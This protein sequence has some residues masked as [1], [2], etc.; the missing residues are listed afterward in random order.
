MA[1]GSHFVS[2]GTI[3]CT[4]Q[5]RKQHDGAHSTLN[6]APLRPGLWTHQVSPFPEAL[7]W[8]LIGG[9]NAEH[10]I[11]RDTRHTLCVASTGF[12]CLRLA[13]HLAEATFFSVGQRLVSVTSSS[14]PPTVWV[15]EIASDCSR[16][17]RR[18]HATPALSVSPQALD[19]LSIS[20]TFKTHFQLSS[21]FE[22]IVYTSYKMDAFHL[23]FVILHFHFFN[24]CHWYTIILTLN[25]LYSTS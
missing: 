18:D 15:W 24:T 12:R 20:H 2:Y 5:L 10:S 14:Q 23:F 1:L 25:D 19:R 17:K 16:R 13:L 9:Q 22:E 11:Q 21:L 3:E 4:G 8:T 6:A 7:P